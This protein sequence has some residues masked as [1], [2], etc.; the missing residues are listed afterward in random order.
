MFLGR[1]AVAAGGLSPNDLRGPKVRRLL[2]GVYAPA[3]TRVTHELLCEA[4]GLLVPPSAALTGRSLATV[5]GVPLATAADDVEVVVPDSDHFG[6]VRGLTIRRVCATAF[7]TRPWRTWRLADEYRLCFDLAARH[8][9]ERAVGHLDAVARAGLV[10][11]GAAARWLRDVRDNDVRAVR[12]AV[13]LADPRAESHRESWLRVILH[14]AGIAVV[15]QFVVRD[16]AGRFVARVDLALPELAIAVEY[17]G[18]WH[19]EA[20]QFE[21]DRDRLN[22]LR[23]AGWTVVSVTSTL[24]GDRAAVVDAVER[25]IRRVTAAR[26]T[27][28]T[29]P[30]PS[31]SPTHVMRA[32][33][34][35]A[36]G[37][38]HVKPA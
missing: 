16:E 38:E 34:G 4:A 12:R 2:R 23:E 9:V 37:R 7:S 14:Q 36:G 22:R 21:R 5:L 13:E 25:E 15:P 17:D 29:P 27:R 10:D 20:E 30:R 3:G 24:L 26:R 35:P 11:L 32:Q 28:P 19:G 6:P 33:R 31:A 1:D 18:L 8:P